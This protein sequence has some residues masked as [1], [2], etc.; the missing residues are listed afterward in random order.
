MRYNVTQKSGCFIEGIP[1]DEYLKSLGHDTF[2]VVEGVP[3]SISQLTQYNKAILLIASDR[4]GH[5][6]AWDGCR[7]FDPSHDAPYTEDELFKHYDMSA[8]NVCFFGIRIH[9]LKRLANRFKVWYYAIM[10]KL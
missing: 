8:M 3:A 2:D 10:V 1:F 5:A 7:I 9:P 4:G 6:V